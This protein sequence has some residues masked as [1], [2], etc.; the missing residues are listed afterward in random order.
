[1]KKQFKGK[2]LPAIHPASIRVKLIVKD[3]IDAL[4]RELNQE[5]VWRDMRYSPEEFE[6]DGGRDEEGMVLGLAKEYNLEV[7]WGKDD[8]VSDDMWV[9]Q[10]RKKGK[11][12]GTKSATQVHNISTV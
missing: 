2:I 12:E 8:E 6:F 1:M 7:S 4:Q 10:S 3:I 9:Q 5:N 11:E